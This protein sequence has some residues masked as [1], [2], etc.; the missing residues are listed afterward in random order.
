MNTELNTPCMFVIGEKE[1]M[2]TA[3]AAIFVSDLPGKY[4]ARARAI[5]WKKK[6]L[7]G[8]K[9]VKVVKCEITY[10]P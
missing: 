9:E 4:G 10:Q 6:Y 5:E 7:K 8:I 2:E 1:K 3:G